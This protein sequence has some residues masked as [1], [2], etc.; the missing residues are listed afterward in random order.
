MDPP[1]NGNV[2]GFEALKMAW[3]VA[4]PY[5]LD[6]ERCA[7]VLK[8]LQNDASY[9]PDE[10]TITA[11]QSRG[12][13]EELPPNAVFVRL[14]GFRG[15]THEEKGKKK[16]QKIPTVSF[17]VSRAAVCMSV[18]FGC[19]YLLN[20][21]DRLC[22]DRRCSSIEQVCT[23]QE[24]KQFGASYSKEYK[25]LEAEMGDTFVLS[26]GKNTHVK[27][28][29]KRGRTKAATTVQCPEKVG[30][31]ARQWVSLGSDGEV[32]VEMCGS[33]FDAKLGRY[34]FGCDWR[35]RWVTPAVYP[36]AVWCPQFCFSRVVLER[37]VYLPGEL[38]RGS[39]CMLILGNPKARLVIHC[40]V[41]VV[42]RDS[43]HDIRKEL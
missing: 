11:A 27:I 3:N 29:C 24:G 21:H 39:L 17:L 36:Y 1:T 8:L 34:S 25:A 9:E 15:F 22:A 32:E 2:Q 10:M 40:C 5:V 12:L 41:M 43:P 31:T 13:S 28:V 4:E 37:E 35:F 30:W 18:C 14:L 16:K 6:A 26:A 33:R 23:E 19:F 20:T 7:E 38:V 42:Y